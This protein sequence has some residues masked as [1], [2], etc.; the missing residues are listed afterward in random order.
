MALTKREEA[1]VGT[2]DFHAPQSPEFYSER[3]IGVITIF[4]YGL[5]AAGDALKR[6]GTNYKVRFERAQTPAAVKK[7]KQVVKALNAGTLDVDSPV[8][9]ISNGR[10]RGRQR[11]AV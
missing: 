8:I 4:Q 7:A 10:P 5:N 6:V 9:S 1:K 11:V 3:Q 2:Y